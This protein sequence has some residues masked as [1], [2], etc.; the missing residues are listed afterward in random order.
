MDRHPLLR[1][2]DVSFLTREVFDLAALCELPGYA[3]HDPETFDMYID[4]ARQLARTR[5]Y[6]LFKEM[7]ASPPTFDGTRVRV[8]PRMRACYDAMVELGVLTASRPEEVGGARLPHT[9]VTLANLHLM[10]ANAGA[11]GFALLTTGA[12]HL[13]EAFGDDSLKARFMTPMYEGRWTG[14]M[15]LTEPHAGSSLAEITTRATP[16]GDGSYRVRGSK[17]FISGGDHDLRENVVHMTLGR[18]DGAPEGIKGVSLFCIPQRR[19]EGDDLI[20]NDVH[21]TQLIHKIGWKALPSVALGFGERDDCHGW[22]VG[23]PG[24]GLKYMFQ[25]MNEARLM[26]GAN[27]VA[28]ASA[29]YHASLDYA[30]TRRQG[31]RL[32]GEGGANTRG[33][34]GGALLVEHPDVRRMLLRQ[35]SIVEGGLALLILTGRYADLA[36]AGDEATRARAAGVLDLL[37]PVAKSFPA[38]W[39]FESNS[40]ALQILGGYGYTTEYLPEAWLRDQRLNAIHEGTTGIQGL[41]LLGRKVMAGAGQHLRAL[42]EELSAD[43]AAAR[44]LPALRGHVDA[45]AAACAAI[46]STTATLGARG[47]AR[48]AVGMLAHADDYLRALSVTL[49]GWMWIKQ[50]AAALREPLDPFRAGKV[51]ACDYWFSAELPRVGPWLSACEQGSAGFECL[52]PAAL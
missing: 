44:D 17:I 5:L 6:P 9:I 19:P 29:G 23:E 2:R 8:H 42:L 34:Q 41:D 50:A 40:L 39:G 24:Q 22:L 47:M 32:D 4:A 46:G 7:D 12:A 31:R 45:L 21:T 11:A 10:A 18:I 27:G 49:V 43:V 52:D 14:T 13:I 16:S 36:E 38:E 33:E 15:A 35:K 51:A 48:D 28:T 26:V 25:M 20:D 30:M 3:H 1:D 37:T